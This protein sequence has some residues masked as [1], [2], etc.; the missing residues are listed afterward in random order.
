MAQCGALAYV[1]I[2]FATLGVVMFFYGIFKMIR[3][4]ADRGGGFPLIAA[5]TC[6]GVAT[7]VNTLSTTC[8]R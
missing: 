4:R 6:L 1:F 3:N 7:Y 8:I 2:Q 5:I